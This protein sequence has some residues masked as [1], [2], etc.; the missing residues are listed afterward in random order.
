[1]YEGEPGLT[2]FAIFMFIF[3]LS[4]F[5]AIVIFLLTALAVI[6]TMIFSN[7]KIGIF[8]ILPIV[9]VVMI[10]I[11]I[12]HSLY[13][14]IFHRKKLIEEFEKEKMLG[15]PQEQLLRDHSEEIPREQAL[16]RLNRIPTLG[17]HELFLLGLT[18]D[19]KLYVVL[20]RPLNLKD[21]AKDYNKGDLL[22]VQYSIEKYVEAKHKP[23]SMFDYIPKYFLIKPVNE[24]MEVIPSEKHL[25]FYKTSCGDMLQKMKGVK[26]YTKYVEETQEGYFS[27]KETIITNLKNV[28]EAEKVNNLLHYLSMF[29]APNEDIVKMMRDNQKQMKEVI[30]F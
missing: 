14:V 5:V 1:V 7:E 16:S 4:I 19:N 28:T 13:Q 10:P 17:D 12:I 2:G 26:G 24:E 25:T 30:D 9:M 15:T 29:D 6:L 18:D 11:M 20:P 8:V 3:R 21:Y 23:K 22:G 27:T